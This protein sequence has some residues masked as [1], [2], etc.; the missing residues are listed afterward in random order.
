[1]YFLY[2]N[3]LRSGWVRYNDGEEPHVLTDDVGEVLPYSSVEL[4]ST[5]QSL[6]NKLVSEYE[7]NK[8]KNAWRRPPSVL[9]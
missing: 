9:I 3:K 7:N 8:N 5:L 4:Y 6:L 1:M 2:N